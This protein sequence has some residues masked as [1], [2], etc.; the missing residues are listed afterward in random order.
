MTA[1][2]TTYAEML[3]TRFTPSPV[4][5]SPN[6]LVAATQWLP[7]SGPTR[8]LDAGV[9][10]RPVNYGGAASFGVWA[11]DWCA[12]LDDL[13][14]ADRKVG[15]RPQIPEPFAAMT[16]WSADQCDLTEPS[17]SEVRERAAQIFRLEEPNAIEREFAVRLLADADTI[18][19]VADIVEAVSTLETELGRTNTQGFVHASIG[20]AA[21]AAQANILVRTGGGFTTPMGHR[22]VFGGGYAD[23]LGDTLIATSQTFGWR[24]EVR[25][26]EAI[27]ASRNEF[28][29]I[30]ERSLVVGYEQHI[31]A[32][33]VTP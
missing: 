18:V 29:A 10:I 5:P 7:E 19:G 27:D 24:G 13:T 20:W 12:Q 6:G 25:Q 4:N 21:R 32:V 17:Q 16:T 28:V 8:W 15:L 26:R 31:G 9:E 3:P 11:A 33:L 22:W 2:V 1:P 30:V 23:G 14:P